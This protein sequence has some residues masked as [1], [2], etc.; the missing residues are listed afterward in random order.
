MGESE[1]CWKDSCW[2]IL[3]V[4][5]IFIIIAILLA[6]LAFACAVGGP[7]FGFLFLIFFIVV[8]VML[9]YWNRQCFMGVMAIFVVAIILMIA[10][11]LFGVCAIP[12]QMWHR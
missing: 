8:L 3:V 7:C 9:Y 12:K 10:L 6:N 2:G 4:I 5:V 1:R 11:I